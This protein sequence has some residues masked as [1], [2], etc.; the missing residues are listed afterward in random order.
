MESRPG[1]PAWWIAAEELEAAG[2]TEEAVALVER[3]CKFQGALLSQAELWERT[4]R[5]LLEAGDRKAAREAWEK[6]SYLA[7]A[8]AASATS[9]GEGA[10][11]S[12]ERDAF[13]AQLGPEP[14][15]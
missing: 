15:L 6:S 1:P 9:G 13:L 5:R 10:A 2:R 3:E 4:M 14:A 11:L 8:Y 7:F 12:L